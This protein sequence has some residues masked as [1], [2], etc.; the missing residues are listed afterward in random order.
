MIKFLDLKQAR[1]TDWAWTA[2]PLMWYKWPILFFDSAALCN[3]PT[4]YVTHTVSHCDHVWEAKKV[5]PEIMV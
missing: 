4:N 5:L 3:S 2:V 1:A